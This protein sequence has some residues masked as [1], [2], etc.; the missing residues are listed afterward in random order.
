MD[1]YLVSSF[2]TPVGDLGGCLSSVGAV[3][4]S[5]AL[6]EQVLARSPWDGSQVG[7][8][9][10]GNVIQA[11]LGQNPSRQIAI[12]CGVSE[13]A[14]AYTVNMVCASGMK[15][16]DLAAQSIA[17]GRRRVVL[18][19][20]V[21]SMSGAPYLV[22]ALR[23]GARLGHAELLDSVV[24]D[25]LTDAFSAAHMG[26][27]AEN[28]AEKYGVSRMEQ[29]AYALESHRRC[30][31]SRENALFASEVVEIKVPTRRGYTTVCSDEHPREDTTLEKLGDLRAVFDPSG[32]ITA[33][34]ASAIGDGAAAML[35]VNG[36]LASCSEVRGNMAVRLRHTVSV[37]CT[38][39]L[40]GMGP[41]LAI[42]QLLNDCSLLAEDIDLWEINEAFASTS[43][44]VIRELDLDPCIVNVNGGAI[45]LGHP[46][47]ATGARIVV[48][49]VHEL[50]RRGAALG[51]AALCVG[52][53]QGMALLVENV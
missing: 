29:D 49:L 38:P 24:H 47:G 8:V 23:S 26:C 5:T 6:G 3:Q 21:E 50:K 43:I 9:V 22:P 14:P 36:D 45:A 11:G 16:I 4:L 27:T 35:V 48:T 12:H 37:G 39:S 46:I 19:G 40:M 10:F 41:V 17:A 42:R 15:A 53:G 13:S 52:G 32:T 34:N 31:R 20:G 2:R 7:E 33:G 1:V 25:G 18:A 28:V 51:I 44:A 30:V